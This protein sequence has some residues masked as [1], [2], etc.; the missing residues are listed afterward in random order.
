MRVLIKYVGR[1]LAVR[2]DTLDEIED[3]VVNSFIEQQHEPT[4]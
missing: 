4:E 2:W 3:I 1:R